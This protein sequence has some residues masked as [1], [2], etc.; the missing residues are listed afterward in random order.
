MYKVMELYD[1]LKE[2]EHHTI[3]LRKAHNKYIFDKTW[4]E[5][6]LRLDED[7]YK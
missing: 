3:T 5:D 2:N 1:V 6:I 7:H 4:Y